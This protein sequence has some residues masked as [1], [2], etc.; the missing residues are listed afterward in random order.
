MV[1]AEHLVQG[2]VERAE[3]GVDL[4]GQV[5]R[6]E[7]ELLAGLDRR[8]HQQDASHFVVVERFHGS[9][10]GKI[11][12]AGTG[13]AE[14]QRQIMFLDGFHQ[15]RLTGSP[16]LDL[17]HIALIA[18]TIVAA[19]GFGTSIG[20]LTTII[21]VHV[22]AEGIPT[23]FTI[24]LVKSRQRMHGG[25]G[26]TCWFLC[27]DAVP[28]SHGQTSILGLEVGPDSGVSHAHGPRVRWCPYASVS[29]Y[30]GEIF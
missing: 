8:A 27:F 11:G 10:D 18:F 6:Q 23:R 29:W 15:L 30:I 21:L 13:R 17:A 4:L 22:I 12:L 3:V 28:F 26:L 14:G 1:E 25:T 20:T 9:G 7:A 2:V 5:P 19:A 24:R 16:W